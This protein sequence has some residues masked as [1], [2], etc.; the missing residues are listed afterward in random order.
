MIQNMSNKRTKYDYDIERSN[1]VTS[2]DEYVL[3]QEI[4]HTLRGLDLAYMK[5]SSIFDKIN[6]ADEIP[7]KNINKRKK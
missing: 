3:Q 6:Q 2:L 7:P 5:Y 1:E 4:A